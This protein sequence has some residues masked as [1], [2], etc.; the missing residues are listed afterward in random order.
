MILKVG[1]IENYNNNI[2]IATE[3]M[4]PGKNNINNKKIMPQP[5][6]EGSKTKV[7]K[8]KANHKRTGITNLTSLFTSASSKL[9]QK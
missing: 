6:M 8:P 3:N 1:T 2:L 9:N 5:L 4:K 7:Y